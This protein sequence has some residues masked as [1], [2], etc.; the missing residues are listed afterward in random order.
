LAVASLTTARAE[1]M[2]PWGYQIIGQ[3]STAQL[4]PGCFSTPPQS[5]S[6][7]F[8]GVT[9]DDE[10]LSERA[11]IELVSRVETIFSR[12]S[13]YRF[14]SAGV[15][16]P[17][18]T[19][20]GGFSEDKVD[21]IQALVRS[22]SD[23]D[24]TLMLVPYA[25]RG[26]RAQIRAMF[27]ARDGEGSE[28]EFTCTPVMNFSYDVGTRDSACD[29]AW[30]RAIQTNNYMGFIDFMGHCPQATEAQ[31]RVA[32]LRAE[33]EERARQEAC[34]TAFDAARTIG[35]AA[36]LR[37]YLRDNADCPSTDMVLAMIE[38]LERQEQVEAAQAACRTAYSLARSAGTVEA[39]DAFLQANANCMEVSAATTLRDHLRELGRA[40]ITSRAGDAGVISPPRQTS[41]SASNSCHDLWYRRNLIFHRNGH[42]FKTPKGQRY[43]DNSNCFTSNPS[44]SAQERREVSRI[45]AQEAANGCR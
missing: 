5:L 43:F 34:Q 26:N 13:N 23:A 4:N 1:D 30:Q 38:T 33:Q 25:K 42:C 7:Y 15:L 20:V 16:Q 32:R 41:G 35:T 18:A 11:R 21:E 31:R 36:A 44:L 3:I 39:F 17:I 22:S 29:A 12:Q 27:W 19:S 45:Q 37:D 9:P 14:R 24:I 2:P 28:R 8:I 40:G 10:T 6:V